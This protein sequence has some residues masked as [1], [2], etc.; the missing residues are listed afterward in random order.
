[1]LELPFPRQED[2]KQ[3]TSVITCL[4]AALHSRVSQEPERMMCA[5]RFGSKVES[6]Y[7]C[8]GEK[9]SWELLVAPAGA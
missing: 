8:A 1:M 3:R 7:T 9:F 4:Q 2:T 5:K 6:N